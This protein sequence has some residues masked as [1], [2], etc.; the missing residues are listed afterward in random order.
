M[1]SNNFRQMFLRVLAEASSAAKAGSA[2]GG[3]G[4]GGGGL[5][6]VLGAAGVG[7][8]GIYG[9]S[10]SL[11]TVQPGH[12]GIKYNRLSGLAEKATLTEGLNLVVPWLERAIVY[13]VR[14]RPQ[15]INSPSKLYYYYY[16]I[17]ILNSFT[18]YYHCHFFKVVA[19]TSR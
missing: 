13:D 1:N 15:L 17:Y 10:H 11:V 7:A 8:L 16:Y 6:M 3:G 4:G 5:G 14:T 9:L 19:K 18:F 2:G 12:L